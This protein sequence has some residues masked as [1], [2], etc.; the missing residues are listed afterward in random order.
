MEDALEEHPAVLRAAV[1]GLPHAFYGEQTAAAVILP[2]TDRE[3]LGYVLGTRHRAAIGISEQ[4]DAIVIVVSE[5]T[6][7][8]SIAYDGEIRRGLSSEDLPTELEKAYLRKTGA[9]RKKEAE[10]KAAEEKEEAAKAE[11]EAAEAPA[12]EAKA[13]EGGDAEEKPAE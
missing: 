8:I 11:A 12:E 3:E 9:F 10:K 4:S 13:D 1:V 6:R 5:E 7:A 2:I